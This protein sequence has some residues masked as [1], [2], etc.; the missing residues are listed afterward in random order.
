VISGEFPVTAP[1]NDACAHRELT[2]HHS[3]PLSRHAVEEVHAPRLERVLGAD[4]EK[5]VARGTLLE[6]R[7]AMAQVIDRRT[8]VGAHRVSHECLE[9][10]LQR[11]VEQRCHRRPHAVNDRTKVRRLT[12]GGALELVERGEDGAALR[13]AEHDD[14]PR[15]ELLGGVLDAPDLRGRDDVPG[16][17]DD[18]EVAEPLIEDDLSGDARVGAAENDR[19]RRLLLRELGAALLAEERLEPA[20]V[21]G[22][23][24][25]AVL[26]ALEGF[27]GRDHSDSGVRGCG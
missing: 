2:T 22:E 26:E 10:V 27:E 9:V 15:A 6:Q 20:D 4:D 17:A 23:A 18:E 13:V 7:G 24:G 14:E 21:G 5:P 8:E 11:R 3:R 25:V 16:D 1:G 12:L 19:V